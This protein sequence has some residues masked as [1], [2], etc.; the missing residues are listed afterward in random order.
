VDKTGTL[1]EGKPRFDR[2][3][4]APGFSEDE[5]LRLS[6]SLDQGSEHPSASAIVVAARERGLALKKAEGFES[7]SG[8]GVVI[9]SM[10]S[11]LCR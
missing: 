6:A 11:L 3:V 9:R 10:K 2:V 8:I 5:V 7:S 1:T 4:A